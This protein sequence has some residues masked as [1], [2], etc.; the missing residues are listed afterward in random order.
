[1]LI[2]N[3]SIWPAGRWSFTGRMV[4]VVA[5]VGSAWWW[6]GSS[7]RQYILLYDI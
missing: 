4:V 2:D 5:V 1:M 7:I 3:T 6:G